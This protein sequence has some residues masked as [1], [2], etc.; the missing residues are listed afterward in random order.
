MSRPTVHL[1]C[2]AHLD[3]VWQW[4]WEEGCA[5]ALSTFATAVEIL[6]EHPTLIFNHNEAVLYQWVQTHTPALFAEIQSLVAVGRWC[7]AG[8]WFLQ[9]DVNL[10]ETE[11]LIRQ[12]TVGR[13]FFRERFGVTPR[14]AY[15]FDSFGHSAGLPQL[16]RLSG[17]ELY[18]HMRPQAPDLALPA[19]LYR[20]RGLDGSEILALRIA[21]G[22]YHTE[23]HNIIERLQEGVALALQLDRDVPVFWG[24]GDHGGGATREDLRLINDFL[25]RESRVSIIHSTTERLYEALREAGRQAP[26]VEGELQRVFT[27]CYTSLARLKRQAIKSAAGL[28]QAE[29]LRAATCWKLGQPFPHSELA[30]VWQDHLF[31]DFH[32]IL[33][34]SCVEPAEQDAL[35]LYGKV[36][37]AT[38]RLRLAA[39]TAINAGPP[40]RRYLP[41]T[42]L[43]TNPACPRVPVEVEAM[44]DLRPKWTGKWHLR[45]RTLDGREVPCQEEQP[46][47]LLPFNGWRRKVSFMADL[48]QIGAQHYE[49]TLHEGERPQPA[50]PL[51]LA[52]RL[53][54]A[55]G[56]V[57]SLDAG[58]GRECLRG[59]LP[60]A[61]VVADTGDAWGT[62]RWSYREVIGQFE[63]E[64]V[65]VVVV[66][67]GPIRTITETQQRFGGSRLV[68][69]T[70]AYAHWPVLEFRFRL[71]WQEERRRLKLALPTALLAPRILCEVPG[72]ALARPADGQEH[73]HRRW[74]LVEGTLAG[75]ATALA[76]VHDGCHGYDF[77]DGEIR[78]SVLRSAAYCHERGFQ[79]GE[80][81][82]R[83]FMDQGVH[84]F[85]LLVTAG[86]AEGV[87]QRLSGLADFLSAPP[88][89]YAH[90]PIGVGTDSGSSLLELSPANVRLLACHA[91]P[92]S[93]A[94]IVRLQEMAG[95]ATTASLQLTGQPAPAALEFRPYEIKTLRCERESPPHEVPL[96]P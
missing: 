42:V 87:R 46:E 66:E 24:I 89:A 77:Q 44:A 31:N 1:I 40:Q 27:G 32:D 92:D 23:R 75:Q 94:L 95:Q 78:L 74:L 30:E 37:E 72:G 61:L 34:G 64:P 36:S 21:V 28:T 12:I 39:A 20:W 26:V 3:P 60:Q 85:R 9:P 10:P 47:A 63:T 14:V 79:L 6:K 58:G 59:A 8:G 18:I 29:A 49:L 11:S 41:V 93:A 83:K 52:H 50:A 57:S 4:R 67:S 48:P 62:D 35:A 65:S 17:Y 76:V 70:V 71:H 2:N 86:D 45:L 56:L 43:N 81:P 96:T 16:L 7:I 80:R 73:V 54:N 5:E 55:S 25:R 91:S 13:A 53:D 19:D 22:L 84:E 90:L 15:N 82:A 38:R 69:Q 88:V 51:A 33:P 68:I